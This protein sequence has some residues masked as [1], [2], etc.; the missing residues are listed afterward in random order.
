MGNLLSHCWDDAIESEVGNC[1]VRTWGKYT[2][3]CLASISTAGTSIGPLY[4]WR[5]I[6]GRMRI[7]EDNWGGG[8]LKTSDI[9]GGGKTFVLHNMVVQPVEKTKDVKIRTR[10]P[11]IGERGCGVNEPLSLKSSRLERIGPEVAEFAVNLLAILA[12]GM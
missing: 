10:R 2:T 1:N 3:D 12:G 8:S 9:T 7:A 4:V 11:H 5:D 6:S